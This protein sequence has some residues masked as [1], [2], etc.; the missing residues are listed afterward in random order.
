MAG[1]QFFTF[2]VSLGA[3]LTLAAAL[4]RVELLGKRLDERLRELRE[5]LAG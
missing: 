5:A 4:Y 2:L 1:S 3:M